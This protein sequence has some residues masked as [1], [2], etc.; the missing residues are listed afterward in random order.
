M[1]SMVLAAMSAAILAA[2]PAE[3]VTFRFDAELL[4]TNRGIEK[5][6]DRMARRA[7]RACRFPGPL[8][9]R[10]G[11]EMRCRASLVD[12]WVDGIGSPHLTA[13][14]RGADAPDF[15]RRD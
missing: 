13:L 15:A 9:T 4:T 8:M 2:G 3:E 10:H 12:Q 6:Y 11:E 7:R 14:H 5:V 1:T